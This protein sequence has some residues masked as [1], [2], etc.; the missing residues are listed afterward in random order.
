MGKPKIK[1]RVFCVYRQANNQSKIG[2]V[3]HNKK[4]KNRE[5]SKIGNFRMMKI[6]ILLGIVFVVNGLDNG[7]GLTPPM[8]WMTWER[9][10]CQLDCENR[11]D[12]LDENVSAN[13][14]T[15]RN[16]NLTKRKQHTTAHQSSR[17]YLVA[18]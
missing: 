6:A 14:K 3:S 7:I 12:C 15:S 18:T 10:R 1:Y 13:L 16:F 5:L 11:T 8:G 17:G 9:F 2:A 4:F